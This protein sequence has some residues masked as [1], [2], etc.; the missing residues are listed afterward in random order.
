MT[1]TPTATTNQKPLIE[2]EC[3]QCKKKVWTRWD[4]ELIEG[5]DKK[6]PVFFDDKE[7]KTRHVDA[8]PAYQGK[9]RLGPEEAHKLNVLL[10]EFA[11]AEAIDT[12]RKHKE[13]NPTF[14]QREVLIL[15]EVLY[16]GL[17]ELV[18]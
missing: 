11:I 5:S 3:K 8:K 15:A 14:E 17:I 16:K 12:M 6:R 7:G 1:Q 18:K 4:W 9:K 13:F 10:I 2:I